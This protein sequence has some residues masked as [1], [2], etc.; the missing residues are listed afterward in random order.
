MN[1]TDEDMILC[2]VWMSGLVMIGL[3]CRIVFGS[4]EDDHHER[5]GTAKF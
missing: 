2:L 4:E 3:I 1:W 5:N